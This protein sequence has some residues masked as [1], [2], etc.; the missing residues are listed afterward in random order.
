[1]KTEKLK[2]NWVGSQFVGDSLS[3]VNKNICRYFSKESINLRKKIPKTEVSFLP[4]FNEK[5]EYLLFLNL[6]LL[7]FISGRPIGR[8]QK[9]GIGFVSRKV[10]YYC[11]EKITRLSKISS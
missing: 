3:I 5:K 9:A 6:T 11:F 2:I 7:L 4:S 1:M 10:K 8:F